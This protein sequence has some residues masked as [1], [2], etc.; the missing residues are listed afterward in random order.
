MQ[1]SFFWCQ[2]IFSLGKLAFLCYHDNIY[3]LLR[4]HCSTL[5]EEHCLY[6]TDSTEALPYYLYI[7][8]IIISSTLLPAYL[9]YSAISK[10]TI[11][12]VVSANYLNTI[13]HCL[14]ADQPTDFIMPTTQF[15]EA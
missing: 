9:L 2:H 8:F 12:C 15:F 6:S 11:L 13:T 5:L 10:V 14:W 7:N 3:R 1:H 4:A